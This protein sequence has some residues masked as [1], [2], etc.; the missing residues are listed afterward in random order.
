ATDLY[1]FWQWCSLFLSPLVYLGVFLLFIAAMRTITRTP[2]STRSLALQ[3]AMTLVPIAFVYHATH[4]YTLLLAQIGQLVPLASD[5]F[6]A[7]WNLFGTARTRIEPLL[8]DVGTIWHTQVALILIGHIAS[9]Y[10]AHVE[11]LRTFGS[12]RA[13]AVSQLPM[14]VLM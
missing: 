5:P 11:A 2:Q 4:Y 14:L 1:Y 10:L 6:G 13:A 12:A 9:V 7:G 8:I 3:F